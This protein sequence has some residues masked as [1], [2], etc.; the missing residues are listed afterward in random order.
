M[1]LESIVAS[2]FWQITSAHEV[3]PPLLALP[4]SSAIHWPMLIDCTI[5][6]SALICMLQIFSPVA[7]RHY[8]PFL[9]PMVAELALTVKQSEVEVTPI[10]VAPFT[11]L[12]PNTSIDDPIGQSGTIT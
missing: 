7:L 9:A 1:Y 10:M 4:R 5:D 12:R 6:H 8:P 3:D 2:F 11:Y